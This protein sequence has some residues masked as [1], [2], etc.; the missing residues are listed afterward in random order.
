MPL[1]D[2]QQT[3]GWDRSY[4]AKLGART[5]YIERALSDT[6]RS[7]EELACIANLISGKHDYVDAT[8]V[9]EHLTYH[10]ETM[11]AAERSRRNP[12]SRIPQLIYSDGR[13]SLPSS[14]K[15]S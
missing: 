1:R 9:T 4:G 8:R 14:M 10:H 6:P 3:D 13:W 5:E 2:L 12:Q 11:G 15:P 7:P